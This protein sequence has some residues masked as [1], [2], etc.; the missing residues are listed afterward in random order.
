MRLIDLIEILIS[1][2]WK[3]DLIYRA[4]TEYVLCISI[5]KIFWILNDIRDLKLRTNKNRNRLCA[6]IMY[7]NISECRVNQHWDSR[8]LVYR[9]GRDIL[10]VA[11]GG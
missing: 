8:G 5:Y 10:Q 11:R 7:S 9:R 3:R 6:F 2:G 1:E 4:H